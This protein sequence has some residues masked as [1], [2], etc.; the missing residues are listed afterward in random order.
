MLHYFV[1]GQQDPKQQAIYQKITRDIYTLADDASNRLLTRNCPSFFYEQTRKMNRHETTTLDE[2][3]DIFSK[4]ADTF[5]F[6]GL[7]EEG[8][9]KKER[10]NRNQ[11][12]YENKMQEMFYTVYT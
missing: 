3:A 2:Y 4:Q 7:L 9:E 12:S 11:L 5:S 10:L 8:E 1:E 6:I